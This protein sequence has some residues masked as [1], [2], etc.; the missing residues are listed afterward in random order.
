MLPSVFR[1]CKNS[2]PDKDFDALESLVVGL[3][4]IASTELRLY[5]EQTSE[6]DLGAVLDDL[7]IVIFPSL[8]EHDIACEWKVDSEL[9][10]VWADGIN[11]IQVFL[12]LTT[13]SIRALTEQES[14]R[15]LCISA[16]ANGPRVTVEVFDSGSGVSRPDDLFRSSQAGAEN[17]GLGLYLSRVFARSFGGELHYKPVSSGTCFIVELAAV[18]GVRQAQ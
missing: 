17:T 10:L 5:A 16:T 7:K 2:T 3:E 1:G 8:S 15:R 6:I 11:L 18:E 13:N 9:P 12:N 14:D 4:E